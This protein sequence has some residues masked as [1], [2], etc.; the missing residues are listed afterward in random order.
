MDVCSTALAPI[1]LCTTSTGEA[2]KKQMKLANVRKRDWLAQIK[3]ERLVQPKVRKAFPDTAFWIADAKTGADGK[4][5][6]KF[7]FPDSLTTWR[8]TARGVT[9]DSKVGS[10]VEKVIVRKNVMVRLVVPRFF[11]QGDEVTIS[12]I[13]HN[14]LPTERQLAC[15]W[16]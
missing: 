3:P 8:A 12:A 5:M 13:V 15:P 4:A 1:V 16:I 10:T 2:G 14:Y 11:R 7:N 9:A 6:V